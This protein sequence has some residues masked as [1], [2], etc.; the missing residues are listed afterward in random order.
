[1]SNN[2]SIVLENELCRLVIGTDG[3]AKSLIIKENGV[4]TLRCDEEVSFFSITQERPY[5]NEVKLAHPNKRT[6]YQANSVE[7]DGDTLIVGFEIV[8]VKARIGVKVAKSYISFELVDF[9]FDHNKH[10][11][12]L[13]M[14][15]PP[16]AEVRLIQLPVLN[17]KN[18]GEW[19]NVSWDDDAA[20]NVLAASPYARIDSERRKGYRIMS[21]DAVRGVKLRGTVASIVAAKGGEKL[22]DSIGELE[23][24]YGLPKGVKSRRNKHTINSSAYWTTNIGPDNVDEHIKYAK[25]GGFRMM[26]IYY[27]A[28]FATGGSYDHCGDYDIDP[29]YGNG[30]EGLKKMLDKIKAAG[31]TP[32]I[33]FLQTHIGLESSYVTPCVDSRL[34]LTRRFTL[35]RPLSLDDTT[36]Y[37]EQDP[38]DTVMYETCRY[39]NFGGELISYESYTTE[40][41]YSFVGCKR[42]AKNTTVKEHPKGLSGGILDI[43]EF[44]AVSAYIDQTTDLQDEIAEKLAVAYKQGFEFI[45]FDG[46]EGTNIPHD[47]YVPYAQYRVLKKLDRE[48]LYTEGAAKAHF[49]WHH[50][51]G[52]NAFDVFPPRIFKESIDKYPLEEAPRMRQDFTRLNFGWWGYYQDT[53]PD[54]FEYGTSRAAA[55]DCPITMMEKLHIF[56]SNKRTLDILEVMRRWEYARANDLLTE[57]D[58]LKLREPGLEYILLINEEGEYELTPYF[59][60][61]CADENIAAFVFERRGASYS[62]FWHKSDEGTMSIKTNAEIFL[63]RDLSKEAIPFTDLGNEKQLPIGNRAYIKSSLSMEELKEVMANAKLI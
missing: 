59:E 1:M 41:P 34:N 53:Q 26:L 56:A 9:V 50:L 58:K 8:P 52:G 21:A 3:L 46:S 40:P 45:Y 2:N 49:S 27:P 11:G 12:G 13:H 42:G 28:I 62:V 38:T 60:V 24:D 36:V 17:R 5:N 63:V 23:E 18:F 44:A 16:V 31:I 43:S 30:A 51:S 15:P 20:V 35:A 29:K 39:L 14:T 37:V 61:K 47:F 54:M 19:L 57:E 6:T 48:P 4:E 22:L 32:G 33:H 55:W 25:L 7:W 10:Y